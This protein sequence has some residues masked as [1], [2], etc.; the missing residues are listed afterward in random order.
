MTLAPGTRLGSCVIVAPIGAGG[1]GEVYRAR[2]TGLK[3]EVAIKVLPAEL[4]RDPERSARLE[5]EAHMIAQMSHP[6]IGAI[7]DLRREGDLVYLL[8]ELVPGVTLTHRLEEGALPLPE[9]MSLFR[10]IAMALEATHARGII[11]RDLKPDNIKITPEGIVKVLDFGLAKEVESWSKTEGETRTGPHDLTRHGTIVGTVAYMSPEQARGR[12]L[13]KRT[14]IW[15][16]GCCL[17]EALSGFRPFRGD[18]AADV[19]A[20]VLKEEP[21]FA[22]LPPGVPPE[23]RKLIKRCLRKDLNQRLRDVGDALVELDSALE[24]PEPPPGR[25]P[26]AIS[27]GWAAAL[28]AI[29]LVTGLLVSRLIDLPTPPRSELVHRFTLDLPAT[30]PMPLDAGPSLALASDGSS[31]IYTARRGDSTELRRRFM[32]RLEPVRVLET[33]GATG[34][35]FHAGEDEIGFFAKS[36]LHRLPLGDPAPVALVE[37]PNPRGASWDSD[38]IVFSPRTESGLWITSALGQSPTPLTELDQDIGERSHR[39]PSILPGGKHALFTSWNKEGFTVEAV[40]L[41][42]RKRT[43]LVTNGAYARFAPTGHLLFV[44]DFALWAQAFAESSLGLPV[45]P[46]KVVES[47]HFDELTGAAFYDV[48]SN[49]T[50]VYAPR[51]EQGG[52]E[53][54]GRLLAISRDGR[55]RLLNPVSREYQVPRLSPSGE[56]ILTIEMEGG[57]TDLWLMDLGRGTRSRVTTDGQ[58]GVPIWHPDGTSIAFAAQRGLV[59]NIF[60][61]P[62]D[63]TKPARRLTESPNFQFPTAWSP[64]GSKLAFV[65]IDAQTR[66]DV[67]IWSEQGV[68]PFLSSPSNEKAAVFSPDGR[69]LAYSSDETGED[70]VYVRPVDGSDGKR[71]ISTAGGREPVWR[72]EEIFY[73]DEE[74]MMAVPI[75]LEGGIEPGQPRALF[76]APFD[77]GE[78]PYANY[79]VSPSGDEFYMVRTDEGREAKRLIV[80]TN[81]FQELKEKVPTER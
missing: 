15:S 18:S 5:R 67:W 44:R 49:G 52:E 79:D 20:A 12:P 71:T 24:A 60:S 41:E 35:F 22:S 76:E 62:I 37:S 42:T 10:Q 34:P 4:S 66:S 58:S 19:H 56:E 69:F 3:R 2:D 21:D 48:S 47:V 54:S 9:A 45:E 29:A 26:G 75:K 31:L 43:S 30:E 57:S 33:E 63:S 53:V 50:L 6:N 11:H 23:I 59:F 74:R 25:G 64:D 68:K 77:E 17:F 8:L 72:G 78:S 14:D 80:V 32:D 40:N 36:Q 28:A 46:T 16:F 27:P 38:R 65:E 7:Y 81:W 61:K 1:M 39:W 73:R 70:E 13:D 51:E 55:P